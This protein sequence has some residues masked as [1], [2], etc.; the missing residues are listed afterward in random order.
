MLFVDVDHC[1]RISDTL[2]H[3][4][5]DQLL[6][7]IAQRLVACVRHSDTVSRRGGMNS[8]FVCRG[9]EVASFLNVAGVQWQLH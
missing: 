5:G 7:S 2:G 4:I 8:W 1:K 9:G 6:K 3:T